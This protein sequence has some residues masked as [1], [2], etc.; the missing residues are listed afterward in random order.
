MVLAVGLAV[1]TGMEE[2]S[3]MMLVPT[4]REVALSVAVA[5]RDTIGDGLLVGVGLIGMMIEADWLRSGE[6]VGEGVSD[7]GTGVETTGTEDAEPV[8]TEVPTDV[9]NSL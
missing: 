4:T 1:G 5:V 3:T 8:A 2:A 9:G 7:A 6:G